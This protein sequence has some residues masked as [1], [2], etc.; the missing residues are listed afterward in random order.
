M[1]SVDLYLYGL[2]SNNTTTNGGDAV[3][4]YLLYSSTTL[5]YPVSEAWMLGGLLCGSPFNNT[6]SVGAI[7]WE[8]PTIIY[9]D[10][11]ILQITAAAI[12]GSATALS[13]FVS[14]YCDLDVV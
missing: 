2:P 4:L 1:L 12:D 14:A 5:I 13:L 3:G 8:K 10:L 7:T 9:V 6:P 11:S